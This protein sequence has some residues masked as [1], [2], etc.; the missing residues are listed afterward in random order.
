MTRWHARAVAITSLALAASAAA[1]PAGGVRRFDGIWEATVVCSDWHGALGY[2][3][4]FP[5]MVS[6]GHLHG[7]DQKAESAELA[8]LRGHNSTQWPRDHQCKRCHRT[9]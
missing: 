2:S 1:Q 5:V 9:V 6:D 8:H 7:Q 4:V 3:K